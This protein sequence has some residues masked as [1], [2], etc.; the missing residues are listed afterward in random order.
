MRSEHSPVSSVPLGKQARAAANDEG[1]HEADKPA[2]KTY[3]G[4]TSL[5]LPEKKSAH[6]QGS[7]QSIREITNQAKHT[8]EKSRLVVHTLNSANPNCK[9]L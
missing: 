2:I 8:E 3:T 5:K 7:E 4:R 1:E 6:M 9:N